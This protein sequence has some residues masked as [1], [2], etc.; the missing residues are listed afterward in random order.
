MSLR[1]F[2]SSAGAL[3]GLAIGDSI[4]SG[5]DGSGSSQTHL[6]LVACSSLIRVWIRATVNGKHPDL[7]SFTADLMRRWAG[8][9]GLLPPVRDDFR[10]ISDWLERQLAE[11]KVE[12][13]GG[14]MRKG[15][16][17]LETPEPRS[18]NS[19]GAACLPLAVAIGA[20]P[21]D[22][23]LPP[24]RSEMASSIVGIT[25]DHPVSVASGAA[26]AVL[27]GD[28]SAGFGLEEAV[29]RTADDLAGAQSQFSGI[30]EKAARELGLKLQQAVGRTKGAGI[31]DEAGQLGDWDGHTA[32]EALVISAWAALRSDGLHECVLRAQAGTKE[33]Y[34]TAAISAS[35]W[36]ASRAAEATKPDEPGLAHPI[37]AYDVF[38]PE[39]I[40]RTRLASIAEAVAGDLCRIFG[41]RTGL[42]EAD[43]ARW[44]GW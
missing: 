16:L 12:I 28:I 44:P 18:T 27:L 7:Q 25:H 3:M 29:S 38:E 41:Q 22:V 1:Q 43:T 6:C 37:L 33:N 10:P 19:F 40:R 24:T 34:A 42:T 2:T 13:V 14:S 5:K 9:Q 11:R 17:S 36:G 8:H 4:A 20:T 31:Y 39:Q 32:D 21:V 30:D 23:D 15:L 35:I 26:L